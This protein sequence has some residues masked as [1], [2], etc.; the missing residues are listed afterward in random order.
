MTNSR[1][2]SSISENFCWVLANSKSWMNEWVLLLLRHFKSCY[3]NWVDDLSNLTQQNHYFFCFMMY[4]E[5]WL[6]WFPQYFFESRKTVTIRKVRVNFASSTEKRWRHH[7]WIRAAD[8]FERRLEK[9]RNWLK[10]VQFYA[11]LGI[12]LLLQKNAVRLIK[13]NL[14]KKKCWQS[15]KD[16]S[17]DPQII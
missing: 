10:I 13:I 12:P 9:R 1:L 14:T 5:K 2:Q 11:K 16:H 17:S 3:V 7:F 4:S 15:R 8:F 6:I